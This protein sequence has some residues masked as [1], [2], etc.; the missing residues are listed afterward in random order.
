LLLMPGGVGLVILD[1]FAIGV[2]MVTTDTPLHGPEIEYLKLGENGLLVECGDSVEV[3]ANEVVRLLENNS[4]RERL[5]ICALADGQEY[6]VENMA[7]RFAD[8]IR[9]ALDTGSPD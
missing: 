9:S 8:G 4:F 7:K 2:P 5:A 3:Y 1:S 6:T